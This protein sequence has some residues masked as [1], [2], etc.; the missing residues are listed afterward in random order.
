[1][2]M[3]PL[4]LAVLLMPLTYSVTLVKEQQ[5]SVKVYVFLICV[6]C[7]VCLIVKNSTKNRYIKLWD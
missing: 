7:M 3:N 5:L 6:F 4:F 2:E 1:M